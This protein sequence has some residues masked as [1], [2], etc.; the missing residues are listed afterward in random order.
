MF[1]L[2]FT[3]TEASGKYPAITSQVIAALLAMLGL[4]YTGEPRAKAFAVY[5]LTLGLGAMGGQLVGG[6]LIQADIAGLGWRSCFLIKV[7]VGRAALVLTPRFV[8]PLKA[9]GHRYASGQ[10]I[11]IGA[12]GWPRQFSPSAN[13]SHSA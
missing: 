10:P 7:P 4:M 6:L 3:L 1:F 5:G 2:F 13:Y 8:P 11:L 9:A 12:A